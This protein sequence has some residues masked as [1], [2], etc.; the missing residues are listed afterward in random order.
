MVA[1]DP[2]Q[3]LHEHW[4]AYLFEGIVL[5]ILGAA[6]IFVPTLATFAI[7]LFL[8]RLFFISGILGLLS[9]FWMRQAPGYWWSLLSA[10]LGLVVGIVLI[11]GSTS[12]AIFLARVLTA[13]FVIEAILSILLALEHKRAL[14]GRWGWLLLNCVVDL[15]GVV[16][17]G[18]P[19]TALWVLGLFVGI[20]LLSHGLTLITLALYARETAPA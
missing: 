5:T 6:A 2:G 14:P 3:G 19:G 11:V 12:G 7:A 17:A 15:V 1:T 10:I 16:V 8:G 18:L 4:G 9:A 13:F 20:D